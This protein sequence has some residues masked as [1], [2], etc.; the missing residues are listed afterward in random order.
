MD[1]A[2]YGRKST[3]LSWDREPATI[4]EIDSA[5]VEEANARLDAPP[6]WACVVPDEIV[7][8]MEAEEERRAAAELAGPAGPA[9]PGAEA[10]PPLPPPLL[11]PA[12]PPHEIGPDSPDEVGPDS[13]DVP[14][15]ET[16]DEVGPD[17]PDVPAS[18][19]SSSSSS[20]SS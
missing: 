18:E 3:H 16:P 5:A 4:E 12:S 20:S 2:H 6:D 7:D 15:S 9:T 19:S 10:P 17:S 8:L 11:A 14:A 1:V 13:P